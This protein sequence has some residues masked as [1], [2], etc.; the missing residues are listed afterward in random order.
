M[1]VLTYTPTNRNNLCQVLTY[2]WPIEIL[3]TLYKIPIT[4]MCHDVILRDSNVTSF[5]RYSS[6]SFDVIN[7]LKILRLWPQNK[8]HQFTDSV[9]IQPRNKINMTQQ[10]K[11]EW[12]KMAWKCLPNLPTSKPKPTPPVMDKWLQQNVADVQIVNFNLSIPTPFICNWM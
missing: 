11:Q 3:D 7:F 5:R 6:W 12:P 4:T 8:Y 9:L 2:I 1:Q 10:S